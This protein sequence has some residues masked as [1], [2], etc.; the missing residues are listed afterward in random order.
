MTIR[1]D[2]IT[3]VF[4]G[5]VSAGPGGTAALVRQTRQALPRS[6]YVLSTWTGSDVSNIDAD[7]I[8]FCE[9]PG[10][11][12]CIKHKGPADEFNNINRQLVSTHCGL[13]QA[14][15]PYAVKMRTDCALTENGF[16][17][18]YER[19]QRGS[20]HARVLASSMFTIDPA[21]FEQMPYHV[22]DWFQFGRTSVLQSYW[23][24]PFMS[25]PDAT[26]YETHGYQ[27]HSTFMDR[28]FRCRLA[29]EQFLTM[30]YAKRYGYP[31]PRYHNDVRADILAGHERFIAE[32][33]I[34]LDPWDIGLV[35]PK[36]EW[37]YR[38]SF[39]RLNC[40]LSMDWYELYLKH[41]GLPVLPELAQGMRFRRGQK[42]I[43]KMLS[44]CMDKAGPLFLRPG[45]KRMVNGLLTGL[46]WQPNFPSGTRTRL[47]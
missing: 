14:K 40:L 44:R 27:R 26:Y 25:Q 42:R 23:Q 47:K 15:T 34:L 12:P 21:M 37:A 32:H 45:F 18:T 38:S 9:D 1:G 28:R 2:D 22:S 33:V 19:F 20:R 3:I 5:P 4:Q 36:Y 11:L 30:H 10:G 6:R 41:G 35:F 17:D 46:T 29:V 8:I 16:V 31:L 7:Q 24:A 13:R 43:A 39:Q